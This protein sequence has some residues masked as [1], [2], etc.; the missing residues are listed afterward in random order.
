MNSTTA[1]FDALGLLRAVHAQDFGLRVST[2]NPRGFRR[3]LY[4]AM[5]ADGAPRVH[6]YQCRRSPKAFLLLKQAFGGLEPLLEETEDASQ[7]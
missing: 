1:H 4:Q 2:N 6:I 3:V 7:S 5:R